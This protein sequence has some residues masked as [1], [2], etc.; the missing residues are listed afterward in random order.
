MSVKIKES[1]LPQVAAEAEYYIE[2]EDYIGSGHFMMIKDKLTGKQIKEWQAYKHKMNTDRNVITNKNIKK[3]ITDSFDDKFH[4]TEIKE[5]SFMSE[6]HKA[7]SDG[8][9]AFNP[10]YYWLVTE[11]LGAE[12]YYQSTTTGRDESPH[13]FAIVKDG[14]VIGSIMTL[15]PTVVFK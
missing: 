12:L 13:L 4:A 10:I 9:N 6:R 15:V 2:S 5:Y 3:A 11:Y 7:V 8:K 14:V 1:T